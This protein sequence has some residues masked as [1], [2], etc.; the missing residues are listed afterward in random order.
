[1][2]KQFLV[3]VI[4]L[5]SLTSFGADFK[6]GLASKVI[7]PELPF[8]MTGFGSRTRPADKVLHD[9]WA[10]AMVIEESPSSRVVIVTTDILGLSREITEEVANRVNQKY[11]IKRSEI[12]LNSSHTHSGPAI[13]PALDGL[14]NLSQEDQQKVGRYTAKLTDDIVEIVGS[15]ISDLKPMNIYSGHGSAEFA[16]NRREYTPKGVI[17]GK[18]PTG[19]GDHDVPVLKITTPEGELKGILFGYACH[20][21]NLSLYEFNGDYA[22]FAQ[23]ELQKAYPGA[24]A[25]FFIG[26]GA[27]QNP[28]PRGTVELCVEHAKELATAVEKVL[29]GNL[30]PVRPPIRTAYETVDLEFAPFTL[31]SFH[32]DLQSSDKYSVI[33]AKVM[34]NALNKGWDV[35]KYRYPLQVIRFNKDL[36]ILGM[37]GET[38][39]GYSLKMK[40]EYSKENLFVMGYCNEV[41]CYIPT[42]QIVQEGGYEAASSM[43]YYD[44]PGPFAENV[45]DKITGTLHS[46]MKKVGAKK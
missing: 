31:E 27:D 10:K 21:T 40:K 36:T 43:I 42:K 24:T 14:F 16:M 46:L 13:W 23:I 37:A 18:N 34:I 29:S 19:I 41:M 6:V 32:K 30:T 2:K 26:C 38:V 8:W 12:L 17:N 44:M 22:G 4:F 15:A 20:N 7:T 45:E 33:R 3:C 9:L 35:S 5:F 25:M 28:Q 39:S 11:G 1:M